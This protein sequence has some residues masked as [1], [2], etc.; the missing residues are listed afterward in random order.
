MR[1]DASGA[2][3][4]RAEK[5]ET[6]IRCRPLGACVAGE[7]K[8][9]VI[10]A[11]VA[12]FIIAVMKLVAGLVSGSASMFAEAAHSFSDVGNQVLLLV[13]IASAKGV[14]SDKHPYGT[15]KNAYFWP[16]IVA[17]LLFGV[18][19]GYSVFEGIEKV[20]HPHEIGSTGLAFG[21]LGV[22]FVIECVSMWIAVREAM[23]AAKARGIGSLREFLRE[24][25]DATLITVLVEDGLAL[26]GLPIAAG[27]LGLALL[28]GNPVWDGV[29]SLIIGAMLMGFALFLATQ[30]RRLLIGIGLSPR[31]VARVRAVLEGDP[32]VDAILSIESMYLGPQVV[33]LGVELDVKNDL[34][35]SQVEASLHALEARLIQELPAL[36]YVYLMPRNKARV[37]A[38]AGE[39]RKAPG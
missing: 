36:K 7:S 17:I 35:G 6:S 23:K 12:N 16:F 11:L 20:R 8:V 4:G 21:V 31:D 34:S 10:A 19:G 39:A 3:G 28:T 38:T 32:A 15:A 1:P 25:R 26:A 18:A 37:D 5:G 24:N 22:A 14:A 2:G 9:A 33:L 27:A 13:G 30:I 29:G